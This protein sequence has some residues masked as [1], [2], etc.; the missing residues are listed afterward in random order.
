MLHES[1]ITVEP[2][3][4]KFNN[5]K[6]ISKIIALWGFSEATLGGILHA[7][8]IPFTGLFVGGVAIILISLI[9]YLSD[10]KG[11]IIKTTLIVITIKGVVSPHTPLTAYFAVFLQGVAAQILF[12]LIKNVRL[13]A[14]IFGIIAMLLSGL[15]KLII[16]TLVFGNTLWDSID[17]YSSFIINEIFS[18]NKNPEIYSLS[19]M[20]MSFYVGIHLIAGIFFGYIAGKLPRWIDETQKS[21]NYSSLLDEIEVI[22]NNHNGK[23]KR[24]SWWKKKSGII[25]ILIMTAMLV[26]SYLFPEFGRGN[27]SKVAVMI[28]RSTIIMIVWIFL[29]APILLKAFHKYLNKKQKSYSADIT[30]IIELFPYIRSI[31]K[32]SWNKTKQLSKLKRVKTFL[33]TTLTLLLL[34]NLE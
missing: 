19:L 4:H 2:T 3:Q 23:K 18:G 16:L 27:V 13:A 6:S 22:K 25:F 7:F 15:Q 10:N 28:L 29:L 30:G 8:N 12:N 20:I 34:M 26:L 24:K 31:L 14:L 5:P 33:V 21:D 17:I 9:A 1:Q 32:F 11:S